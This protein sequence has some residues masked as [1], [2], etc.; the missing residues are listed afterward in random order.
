M[1]LWNYPVTLPAG[2]AASGALTLD[3]QAYRAHG[4]ALPTTE[5]Q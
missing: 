1:E 2:T 5:A 4:L 3:P